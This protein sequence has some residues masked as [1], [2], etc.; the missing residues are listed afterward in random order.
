M[1]TVL[2][3]V[4]R[5][6]ANSA[7]QLPSEVELENGHVQAAINEMKKAFEV[8]YRAYFIYGDLAMRSRG[9]WTRRNPP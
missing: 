2:L 4:R 5:R 6:L 9:K 1:T 3:A 8:G 7:V